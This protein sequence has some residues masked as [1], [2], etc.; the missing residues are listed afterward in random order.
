[1]KLPL[2]KGTPGCS[3]PLI[4]RDGQQ[5]AVGHGQVAQEGRL[6][7]VGIGYVERNLELVPGGLGIGQGDRPFDFGI[8]R[9]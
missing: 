6:G 3:Q 4:L 7:L 5:R 9:V 1:M 8:A 2:S